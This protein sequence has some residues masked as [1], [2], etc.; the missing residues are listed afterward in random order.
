MVHYKLSSENS[1]E[2]LTQ[3]T[4]VEPTDGIDEMFPHSADV[5]GPSV[6]EAYQVHQV[7]SVL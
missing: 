5:P 1:W 6:H 3:V 4:G 7:S 2:E